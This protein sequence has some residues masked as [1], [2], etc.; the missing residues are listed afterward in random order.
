MH[1]GR[2]RTSYVF[3]GVLNINCGWLSLSKQLKM[4]MAM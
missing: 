4:T 2:A 1:L 3:L